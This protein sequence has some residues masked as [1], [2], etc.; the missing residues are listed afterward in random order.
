ML[1]NKE[2]ADR[3][4]AEMLRK[5]IERVPQPAYKEAPP[6]KTSLEEQLDHEEKEERDE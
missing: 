6:L 1:V 2:L 5:Y 3:E 4:W